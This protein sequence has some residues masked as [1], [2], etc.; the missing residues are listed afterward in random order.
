MIHATWQNGR[1]VLDE[2]VD[3]PEGARLVV[4]PELTQDDWIQK[5][6]AQEINTPE[7]IEA[8]L[9]WYDSLE[10]L[11]VMPEEEADLAAWRE[12]VK[13]YTIAHMDRESE[14]LFE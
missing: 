10:P 11:I 1:V 13:Q 7:A 3:W 8:W 5:A 12:K 14:E 2:P 6:I 4:Q 9:K